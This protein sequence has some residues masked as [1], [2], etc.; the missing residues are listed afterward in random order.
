[1]GCSDDE[2]KRKVDC[3]RIALEVDFGEK[4]RRMR[5]I[6][7][8]V[9]AFPYAFPDKTQQAAAGQI[10][11]DFHK[12]YPQYIETT[13]RHL[14]GVCAKPHASDAFEEFKAAMAYS[15]SRDGAL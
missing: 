3:A 2:F 11:S 4:V 14:A 1:M 8:I 10:I 7:E 12:K 9:A 5:T 15:S 13:A 6:V